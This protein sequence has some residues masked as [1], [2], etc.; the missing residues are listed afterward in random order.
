MYLCMHYVRFLC[1]KSQFRDKATFQIFICVL[2]MTAIEEAYAMN[3][4]KLRKGSQIFDN[5]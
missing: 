5:C 4:R 1:D 3:W 2:L